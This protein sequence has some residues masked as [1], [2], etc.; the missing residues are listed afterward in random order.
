MGYAKKELIPPKLVYKYRPFAD[1]N[2]SVRR[3][4]AL[5]MWWFG[6][7]RYFDDSEDFVFPGVRNDRQLAPYDLER[8]QADMQEVLDKTGVFCLSER[9]GHPQLRFSSPCNCRLLVNPVCLWPSVRR[10]FLGKWVNIDHPA[11]TLLI[12]K[13]G[14]KFIIAEQAHQLVAKNSDGTLTPN[15]GNGWCSYLKDSDR[16]NCAGATYKRVK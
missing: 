6:S 16:M 3:M 8:A 11:D 2:D 5:N 7:R 9:A 12:S 14:D 1:P 4:L 13:D 10:E 15:N